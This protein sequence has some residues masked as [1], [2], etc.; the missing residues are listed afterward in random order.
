MKAERYDMSTLGVIHLYLFIYI[1]IFPFPKGNLR[2]YQV[3]LLNMVFYVQCSSA[4]EGFTFL[5]Q[6]AQSMDWIYTNVLNYEH[7]SEFWKGITVEC[8]GLCESWC[9]LDCTQFFLPNVYT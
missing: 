2:E 7:D 5:W 1:Y 6:H 8:M 4:T 3:L 9:I